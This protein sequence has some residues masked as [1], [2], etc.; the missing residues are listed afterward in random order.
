[1]KTR[2]ISVRRAGLRGEVWTRDLPNR[3]QVC[4]PLDLEVW[5]ITILFL[6]FEQ[7]SI[8]Q[9]SETYFQNCLVKLCILVEVYLWLRIP[10]DSHFQLI[11]VSLIFT[12]F[13]SDRIELLSNNKTGFTIY[14][15]SFRSFFFFR[16]RQKQWL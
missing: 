11:H 9:F 15:Q 16:Q 10:E 12:L 14:I 1:M 7:R 5:S 6:N 13:V 3:V 2:K 8:T 4:K